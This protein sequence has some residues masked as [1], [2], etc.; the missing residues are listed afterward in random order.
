MSQISV[1]VF[2][3]RIEENFDLPC[4][5]LMQALASFYQQRTVCH[6]PGEV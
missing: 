6:L 2:Q 1:V 5:T 3:P 4:R